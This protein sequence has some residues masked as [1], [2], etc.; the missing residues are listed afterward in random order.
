M[1]NS[2]LPGENVSLLERPT[3]SVPWSVGKLFYRFSA[4]RKE[5]KIQ[6]LHKDKLYCCSTRLSRLHSGSS[7]KWQYTGGAILDGGHHHTVKET[8]GLQLQHLVCSR[9]LFQKNLRIFFSKTNFVSVFHKWQTNQSINQPNKLWVKHH[10][11]C[12]TFRVYVKSNALLCVLMCLH[13]FLDFFSSTFFLF[14][15]FWFSFFLWFWFSFFVIFL[16]GYIL[17]A[18]KVIDFRISPSSPAIF[19]YQIPDGVDRVLVRAWSPKVSEFDSKPIC[20]Y[21]SIQP[22]YCPVADLPQEI[23]SQVFLDR[24]A[25]PNFHRRFFYQWK[26]STKRSLKIGLDAKKIKNIAGACFSCVFFT[27]AQQGILIPTYRAFTWHSNDF[28][29]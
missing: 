18:E 2:L 22:A 27:I 13:R 3:Y 17:E 9:W 21:L 11:G 8:S 10:P 29:P 12:R 20:S 14:L 25:M 16:V 24:K 28:E 1:G 4:L 15:W 7:W 26:K 6:F 19:Q 5:W 23:T